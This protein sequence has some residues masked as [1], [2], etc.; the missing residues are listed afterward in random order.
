MLEFNPIHKNS[1]SLAVPQ[2]HSPG[3]PLAL[4]LCQTD[5]IHLPSFLTSLVH[6]LATLLLSSWS[7]CLISLPVKCLEGSWAELRPQGPL[8]CFL[9]IKVSS[10][11]QCARVEGKMADKDFLMYSQGLDIYC[12][13]ELLFLGRLLPIQPHDLPQPVQCCSSWEPPKCSSWRHS[14]WLLAGFLGGRRWELVTTT[15]AWWS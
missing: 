5:I 12:F 10:G 2:L 14:P 4:L 7:T 3:P 6:A 11:C 15:Q 9:F 8:I 13:P 1:N